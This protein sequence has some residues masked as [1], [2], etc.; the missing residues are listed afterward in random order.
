MTFRPLERAHRCRAA[1]KREP[2]LYERMFC[3]CPRW[4]SSHSG[5]RPA[6]FW[7]S[8]PE[9]QGSVRACSSSKFA[10]PACLKRTTLSRL[11]SDWQ[12][13]G[14]RHGRWPLRA[15]RKACIHGEKWL[16]ESLT[17]ERRMKLLTSIKRPIAMYNTLVPNIYVLVYLKVLAKFMPRNATPRH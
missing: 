4:R 3:D 1:C 5:L 9:E 15:P 17:N 8:A 13:R 7:T 11:S 6:S 2:D 10:Q 16:T 12:K 14:C